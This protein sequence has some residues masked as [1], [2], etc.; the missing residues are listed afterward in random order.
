MT[1]KLQVQCPTEETNEK[2]I[3]MALYIPSKLTGSY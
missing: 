1:E 2:N 3:N